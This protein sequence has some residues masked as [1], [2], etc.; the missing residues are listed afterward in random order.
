MATTTVPRNTTTTAKDASPPVL[1]SRALAFWLSG[2]LALVAVTS[3][4]LTFL[5]PGILRGT[6]VMNG[7]ARGTALVIVLVAVPVLAWSLVLAWRGSARAILAWL[8]ASGALA[9]NALMFLFATP[10]NRLFPLYLAMLSLSGFSIASLVAR[11]DVR[12]LASRFSARVPVR[13]IAGY[14]WVIVALNAVAWVARIVPGLASHGAPGYL[15]G[16]GLTTNVVFVQDLALWLP[17]MAIAAAW[18][19]RRRPAGYLVV[20]AGLIMWMI[21]S[22]CVAVDQWYGHA[23]DPAS[24]VASGALV[25]VFAALAVV[26]LVPVCYL[27]RG[28]DTSLAG[29]T[30]AIRIPLVTR[31]GW[32]AWLLTGIALFLT[33][34][35]IFGGTQLVRDGFGMPLSWLGHT[36]FTSW[37]LPGLALLIGVAVPQLT[38]ALL[39]ATAHRLALVA[40][41]LAG[42]ALIAWIAIQLLVLQRYFFLQPVI[43]GFGVA[44]IL[45]ASA[46]QRMARPRARRASDRA[47]AVPER[48]R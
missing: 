29:G 37:T 1:G 16:T 8:G 32:P 5:L 31:R 45:L 2:A 43:V 22:A 47:A 46:W 23:A 19:W 26:G 4:L 20:G 41:Y 25:P 9:Y 10:V 27:L 40:S 35:A 30:A 13:V 14:V 24:Q 28:F 15:R 12:A 36:P 18:L 39:I 48:Q 44:E 34:G 21:E 7:S 42:I 3:A 17:L 38:A 11:T 6:A 33:A